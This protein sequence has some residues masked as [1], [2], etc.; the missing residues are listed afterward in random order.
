MDPD[1]RVILFNNLLPIEITQMIFCEVYSYEIKTAY[2]EGEEFFNSGEGP[3]EQCLYFIVV[4]WDKI[5]LL[6][7]VS[8]KE[9][10]SK[11]IEKFTKNSFDMYYY[12][13]CVTFFKRFKECYPEEEK[14]QYFYDIINDYMDKK[15]YL[16]F[17]LDSDDSTDSDSDGFYMF[18]L[19]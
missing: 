12:Y 7:H 14:L 5:R 3:H 1:E 9:E 4:F 13:Q 2:F 10:G 8:L 17:S 6:G 18:S 19:D 11:I 16:V 15:T